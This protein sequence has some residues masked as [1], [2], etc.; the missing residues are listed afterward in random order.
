VTLNSDAEYKN[1]LKLLL[2]RTIDEPTYRQFFAQALFSQIESYINKPNDAYRVVSIGL[3]PSI[4]QFNG[5]YTLDSYQVNYDL[6]YK[7]SFRRIIAPELDKNDELKGYFDDWGNR[8]YIFVDEL[9]KGKLF[10]KNENIKIRK[11][12]LNTQALK[13]MGG[14]YIFSSV[15]IENYQE[16][17]LTFESRFTNDDS[18]WDIYLYRVI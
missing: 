3:H 10:G 15:A 7:N 2:G 16:N 18:F 17:H 1:N 11:L 8:C 9:G 13:E 4:A 5:Y 12:D 6:D 14:E